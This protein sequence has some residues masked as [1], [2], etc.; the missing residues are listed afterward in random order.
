[1][2]AIN[3]IWHRCPVCRTLIINEASFPMY[4]FSS[5]IVLDIGVYCGICLKELKIKD[6]T[7]E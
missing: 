3:N 1:M 6:L 7:A 2:I 4:D 5:E